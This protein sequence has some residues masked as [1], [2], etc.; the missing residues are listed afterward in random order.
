RQLRGVVFRS[1]AQS[2]QLGSRSGIG[3]A[4]EARFASGGAGGAA[5]RPLPIPKG[6]PWRYAK[7]GELKPS[8]LGITT[9]KGE[10]II[11][12]GLGA[13]LESETIRHEAGHRFLTPLGEGRLTTFR[14][15]AME[16]FYNRSV[17]M[18]VLEESAVHTYGTRNVFRGVALPFGGGYSLAPGWGDLIVV[19]MIGGAAYVLAKAPEGSR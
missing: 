18:R 6:V 8:D 15:N 13:R 10:I 1:P 5:G 7:P 19:G 3:G 14:Q 4:V 9:K 17:I 2:G 11:R 16:W 12:R